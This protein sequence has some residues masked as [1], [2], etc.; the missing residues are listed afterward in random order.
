MAGTG[1]GD[2]IGF[3]R[4]ERTKSRSKIVYSPQEGK[5]FKKRSPRKIPG[6]KDFGM[7]VKEVDDE[8]REEFVHEGRKSNSDIVEDDAVKFKGVIE[9][10]PSSGSEKGDNVQFD[11][12]SVNLNSEFGEATP[13]PGQREDETIYSKAMRKKN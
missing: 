3:T 1:G 7:A 13:L 6:A 10:N 8:E 5:A 11:E 2:Y 9:V 4:K 12:K